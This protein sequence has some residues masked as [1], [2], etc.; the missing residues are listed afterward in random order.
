M[1]IDYITAAIAESL[2]RDH[3]ARL[4]GPVTDWHNHRCESCGHVWRHDR[5][6]IVAY[7]DRT[8]D[9]DHYRTEHMC[10][11]CGFGPQFY[12]H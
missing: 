3:V 8:G 7:I 10:P 6:A 12:R 9:T 5:E 11:A 2:E 1:L 4:N